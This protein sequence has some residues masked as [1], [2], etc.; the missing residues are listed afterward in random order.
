MDINSTMTNNITQ[1]STLK[2]RVLKESGLGERLK[3]ARGTLRLSER[4]A[5]QRL[6]LNPNIISIIESE[7]FEN[8]PPSTFMRGYIR[9]YARL[10]NFPD[11][12]IN[13]AFIE[14]ETHSPQISTP[15]PMRVTKTTSSHKSYHYIRRTTFLIAAGLVA[16]VSLWWA[17]HPK[18]TIQVTKSLTA[19]TDSLTA[20]ITTKPAASQT[21]P[22]IAAPAPTTATPAKTEPK[23]TKTATPTPK[24]AAKPT[25][26]TATLTT[27]SS[28][29][30]VATP[31]SLSIKPL[32]ATT[33][34]DDDDADT[35]ND[36]ANNNIVSDSDVYN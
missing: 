30:T 22:A 33:D 13:A 34:N 12:E 36:T 4:D 2:K 31:D 8:G 32:S 16:L 6:H 1:A 23:D 21:T 3:T 10:L 11:E 18:D 15:I 35:T 9:S 29:A 27:P 17:S 19:L 14:L 20:P 24:D 5:A 28:A 7:D 26:D 25:T